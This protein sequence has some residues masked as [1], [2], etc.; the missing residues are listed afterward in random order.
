M[1]QSKED[2]FDD[3]FTNIGQKLVSQESLKVI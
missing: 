3:F 1:N 2:T